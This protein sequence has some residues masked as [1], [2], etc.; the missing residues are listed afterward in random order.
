[1]R[2]FF[3]NPK[4]FG[5]YLAGYLRWILTLG[6]TF[7]VFWVVL[8]AQILSS[9]VRDFALLNHFLCKKLTFTFTGFSGIGIWAANDS[10]ASVVRGQEERK[11]KE[12]KITAFVM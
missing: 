1:M 5:R 4:Y 11:K 3:K 2:V 6:N 12:R 7:R 8:S 9:L 10:N